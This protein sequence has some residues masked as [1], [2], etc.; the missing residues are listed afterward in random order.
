GVTVSASDIVVPAEKVTILEEAQRVADDIWSKRKKRIIT[1]LE[2]D[3]EVTRIWDDATRRLTKAM[4]E[5]FD[6]LNSINMMANSC[7]RGKKWARCA[8][9]PP[10]V[11]WWW[12]RRAACWTSRSSPTSARACPCS[13]TSSPHTAA[14]RDW[15]TRR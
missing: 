1:E 9:W 14:G 5:N 7:A 12:A 8:K 2:K 6:P 10:C 13:S 15:S 3:V 11:A 4:K